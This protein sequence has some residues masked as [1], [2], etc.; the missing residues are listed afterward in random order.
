V[1]QNRL[2]RFNG[3]DDPPAGK[4]LLRTA[5]YFIRCMTVRWPCQVALSGSEWTKPLSWHHR[6]RPTLVYWALKV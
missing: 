5:A 1:L 6:G 3:H 4:A 2:R